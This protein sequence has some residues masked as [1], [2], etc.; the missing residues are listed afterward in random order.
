MREIKAHTGLRGIAAMTVFLGH[1]E[2]DH[3]WRGAFWFT[4]IY[5]FFYW[6]SR[7]VDLFFMLSGFVLNYVYLKER[8]VEWRGFFAARF[9]RIC[10]LYYA[11]LFAVLAMNLYSAHSGHY[12][13]PSLKPSILLPN[14]AMVQEWPV[15]GFVPSINI[16]SWSISAEVFLYVA[17]F[18]LL[19]FLLARQSL[20]RAVSLSAILIAL[21][22][23]AIVSSDSPYPV[24]FEYAGLTLGITGFTAGFL[25]CELL[26]ARES[27][28]IPW[29]AEICLA[30]LVLALLPFASVHA[31]L[32][33]AFAALIAVTYSPASRLGRVLG[34]P[35][36]HYLGGIS[37]SVYIWQYPVL[38]ACT[39]AFGVRH[40]G[41][42]DLD[43]ASAAPGRKLLYCAGTIVT[44]MLVAN[45][46]YY[47][48]ESPLRRILRRPIRDWFR[49]RP[50]PQSAGS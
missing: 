31:L 5:S 25:L 44:L 21:L 4:G 27:P 39:L 45:V 22:V 46:S 14:L 36:F 1:A 8:R 28:L 34:S 16:P 30:V 19:A 24:H 6:Q 50:L 42:V 13:S 37:Y 32:P 43:T 18:P 47:W 11:G 20:S 40:M 12:P 35:F 48:F 2:F 23:N 41:N 38:K 15:A 3:L 10:P 9:A 7:A 29:S 49:A 17:I 33:A 26:Y